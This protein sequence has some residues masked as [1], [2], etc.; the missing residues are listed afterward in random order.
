MKIKV[1][2]VVLLV[3]LALPFTASADLVLVNKDWVVPAHEA[4]Q[5]GFTLAQTAYVHLTV[6][7]VKNTDKGFTVRIAP[8]EDAANCVGKAQGPCRSR[9][10]FD[11]FKV[12][13]P[14]DHMGL[15]PAGSWSVFVQNSENILNKATVHVH[16]TAFNPPQA[17]PSTKTFA[18]GSE[19]CKAGQEVCCPGEGNTQGCVKDDG[20]EA[21]PIGASCDPQTNEPCALPQRCLLSS[22]PRAS[23]NCMAGAP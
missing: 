11:A 20:P 15:V 13:G 7:G 6:M 3:C 1:H 18:C 2:S 14:Y 8:Q 17:N 16:V 12:P 4:Y 9:A 5:Q 23:Y 21:C 19:R 10:D 22:P